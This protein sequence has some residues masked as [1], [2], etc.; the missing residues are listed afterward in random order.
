MMSVA[1][2]ERVSVDEIPVARRALKAFV[3]RVVVRGDEMRIDYSSSHRFCRGCLTYPLDQCA[4]P[5]GDEGRFD[6]EA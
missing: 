1:L 5:P 6:I 4:T 2:R 3:E